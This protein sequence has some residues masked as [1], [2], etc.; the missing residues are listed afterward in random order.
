MGGKHYLL[1]KQ[2]KEKCIVTS[3]PPFLHSTFS[4]SLPSRKNRLFNLAAPIVFPGHLYL[5]SYGPALAWYF[6]PIQ[7][8]RY[9]T[10]KANPSYR[11]LSATGC[12]SGQSDHRYGRC[13]IKLEGIELK[14]GGNRVRRRRHDWMCIFLHALR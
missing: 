13:Y 7:A 9:L 2:T 4:L 12:R 1:T 3:F 6:P 10:S 5:S 11:E 8:R 14:A